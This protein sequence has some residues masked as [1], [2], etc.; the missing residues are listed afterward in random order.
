[1]RGGKGGEFERGKRRWRPTAS[2]PPQRRR[3]P[4]DR[5]DGAARRLLERGPAARPPAWS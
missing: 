3:E 2:G 5:P 4:L 1:V